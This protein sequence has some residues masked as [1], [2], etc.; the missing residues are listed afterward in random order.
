MKHPIVNWEGLRWTRDNTRK[1]KNIIINDYS[2]PYES[3]V[4]AIPGWVFEGLKVYRA[5][6]EAPEGFELLPGIA[7][8]LYPYIVSCNNSSNIGV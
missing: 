4:H 3:T 5:T 7:E 2:S 8:E 6:G 1:Y